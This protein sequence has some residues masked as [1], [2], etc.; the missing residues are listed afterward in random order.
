MIDLP[1]IAVILCQSLESMM[2]STPRPEILFGSA[3]TTFGI[4]VVEPVLVVE[5]GVSGRHLATRGTADP[6]DRTYPRSDTRGGLVHEFTG[7]GRRDRGG[8][9]RGGVGDD[10]EAGVAR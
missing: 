2:A 7:R 4:V 10:L 1:T 5:V 9:E 8:F 3:T 6:I